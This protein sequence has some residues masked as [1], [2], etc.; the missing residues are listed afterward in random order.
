MVWWTVREG[1]LAPGLEIDGVVA[2]GSY[3]DL[4]RCDDSCALE[5][6]QSLDCHVRLRAFDHWDDLGCYSP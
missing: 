6:R 3:C 5:G 1:S 4:P 2:N